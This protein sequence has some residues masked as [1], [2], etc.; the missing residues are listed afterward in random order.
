M[1]ARKRV[2]RNERERGQGSIK[3]LPD[4]RVRAWKP[5][6]GGKRPSRLFG[7]PDARAKAEAWLTGLAAGPAMTV[8]VWME[9]WYARRAPTLRP[10]S[11]RAYACYFR[12]LAPYQDRPL[13]SITQDDWQDLI[14][15]LLLRYARST[16][17]RSRAIWSGAVTAAV[18]AGHIRENTLLGTKLGRPAEKIPRAWRL[19]EQRRLL[20]RAEGEPHEAWLHAGLA[21]GM[22]FEELRTL[23][24]DD[25]DFVRLT[26]LVRQSK[27]GRG[28]L[29]P[30][31]PEAAAVIAARVKRLQP[32]ARLAFGHPDGQPFG[33]ATLRRWL[34]ALCLR[35]KVTVLPPHS[36]RHSYS[37]NAIAD[38]VDLPALAHDLGH[39]DIGVTSRVYASYIT[40]PERPTAR[41]VSR[42][43]YGASAGPK[44][45]KRRGASSGG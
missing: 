39:R 35:A 3:D 40:A 25:I 21:T 9:T 24:V 43:L 29:I 17:E 28:R 33:A 10:L 4:G 30:L 7:P 18:R 36:M 20:A 2:R 32:G 26:V 38:G 11:R 1:A 41:A 27:S 31:A 37:S 5:P 22:R 8:S 13:A 23:L 19:D 45:V 14:N 15:A 44:S 16:V 34:R 42:Q 6:Q 12:R